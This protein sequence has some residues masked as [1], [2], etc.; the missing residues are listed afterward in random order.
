MNKSKKEEELR[1]NRKFSSKEKSE[2]NMNNSKN[3]MH[4]LLIDKESLP[5]TRHQ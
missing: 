1:K 2:N 5:T 4:K 3:I